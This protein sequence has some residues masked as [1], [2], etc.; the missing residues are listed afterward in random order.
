[1]LRFVLRRLAILPFALVLI[2]FLG[3]TYAYIARPIRAA[4]TP[5]LRQQVSNP[6]PLLESY[7]Q[8]ISGIFHGS[9]LKPFSQGPQIGSVAQDI[10]NSLVASLGL[11]SIAI[12]L[13]ILFGIVLGLLAVRNQPPGVR[14]WMSFVSTI[15]LSMPSFYIGSLA[16]LL[17][18]FVLVF[19]GPNS[20]SPIPIQGFGWDN[21]L[22]LPVIALMLRPSVQIAQV[23]AEMLAGEFGKQYIIASRSF[24]H[25]WHDIRWRQAMRNVLAPIILSIAGSFRLLVGELIVVEWLFNWPGLGKMLASTLVPGS[26]NT[27]LGANV[28]FLDPAV[29]AADIT[30]IGLFFL[31]ADL[32]ASISVRVVDPRL[33]VQDEQEPAGGV[34]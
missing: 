12:S 20:E 5:Y 15:G 11:L 18:V 16:I 2:N 8:F 21:H 25:T 34:I 32:I 1:M 10:V 24:G 4:S 30:F 17:I 31:I 27:N 3:F 7:A 19:R 14:G 28:L 9:L 29:V 23:T 22:I 33:R 6:S 26:L 13:S